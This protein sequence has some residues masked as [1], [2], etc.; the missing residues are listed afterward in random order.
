L[1]L[2][3]YH[4]CSKSFTVLGCP[5][6]RTHPCNQTWP[7][8]FQI[9][10]SYPGRAQSYLPLPATATSDHDRVN[11]NNSS[12]AATIRFFARFVVANLVILPSNTLPRR[13]RR[14]A[15]WSTLLLALFRGAL[16]LSTRRPDTRGP[17]RPRRYCRSADTRSCAHS[18]TSAGFDKMLILPKYDSP[19]LRGPSLLINQVQPSVAILREPVHYPHTASALNAVPQHSVSSGRARTSPSN[20]TQKLSGT[21]TK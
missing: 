13:L 5:L 21:S 3:N 7:P 11:Q 2:K 9:R 6:D 14:R 1:S 17:P 16:A 15:I 19:A 4:K 18:K 10:T 20:F 12:N 8:R